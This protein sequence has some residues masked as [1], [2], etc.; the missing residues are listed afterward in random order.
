MAAGHGVNRRDVMYN[1]FV[2]VGPKNDPAALRGTADA[3]EAMKKIHQAKSKFISRGDESGT[4]KMELGLWKLAS[5]DANGPWY[6][7]A[8][9]GMGEVLTIA[10][11]MEGYTLTDRATYSAYRSKTGLEILV[12]GDTKL[13]NP[14]GVMAVNPQKYSAV[15]SAGATQFI[16]WLTS[17]EGQNRIADFKI[18]GEQLFFP[19]AKQATANK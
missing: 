11:Q 3:V 12:A 7:S 6:V 15:N 18:N 5:I 4:H 8:G 17:S 9:Q 1:D 2:I 13:F 14:Y 19:N 10:A 16:E